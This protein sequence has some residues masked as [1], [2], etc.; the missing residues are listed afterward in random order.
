MNF[1]DG[2]RVTPFLPKSKIV[3]VLNA[4]PEPHGYYLFCCV[5]ANWAGIIVP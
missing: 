4:V 1:Y 3:E 5:N 2:R